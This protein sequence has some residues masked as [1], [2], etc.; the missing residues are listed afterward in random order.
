MDGATLYTLTTNLLGGNALDV[1]LFYQLLN[2]QKNLREMQRDWMKLRTEDTSIT[3][4]SAD[5][6]LTGKILP[7]RFLRTYSFYDQYG[8]LAGPFIVT[9]GGSKVP[10]K[11]I[12]FEQRY[13]YQNSEGYYYIDTKNGTIGRTGST[14]GTLHLFFL[15]GTVDITSATTWGLPPSDG[16]GAL[17]AYDVAVEQKGGIDWDTI[18]ANQ[19]PYNQRKIDQLE[20]NLATW[21]ARLQQAELGV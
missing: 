20:A 16:Y 4:T 2:M 19:V 6:Y 12:K 5:T 8:Q 9:S 14:A 17:L 3:F 13:D 21:D 18:N 11:P 7:A 15:Q 10:L 1:D